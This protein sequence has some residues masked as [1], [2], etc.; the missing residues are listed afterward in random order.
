[1]RRALTVVI[2]LLLAMGLAACAPWQSL[3]NPPG[4]GGH[5]AYMRQD[6]NAGRALWRVA[7]LVK[8]KGANHNAQ[9]VANRIAWE[10]GGGCVLGH[11]PGDELLGWYGTKAGE[12]IACVVGCIDSRTA[13]RQFWDSPTHAQQILDAGFHRIGIGVQCSG[14]TSYYAVHFVA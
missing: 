4:L 3:P 9:Y 5:R 8:D 6:H 11:T 2:A 10:S 13:M 14:S 1:M 7:P 12:N